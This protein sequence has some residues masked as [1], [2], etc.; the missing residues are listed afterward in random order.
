MR[1]AELV[2][3]ALNSTQE[4]NDDTQSNKEVVDHLGTGWCGQAN[5]T[6]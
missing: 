6:G 3:R 5:G 1:L 4:G 2:Q